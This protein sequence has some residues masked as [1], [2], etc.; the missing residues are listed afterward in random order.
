MNFQRLNHILV[1]A[2]SEDR[3]RLRGRRIALLVRPAMWAYSSLSDEGQVLAVMMLFIGTAAG[4][5]R[6]T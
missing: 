3:D 4:E 5:G 2:R 1:P 6:A